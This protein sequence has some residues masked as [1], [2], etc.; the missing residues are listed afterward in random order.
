MDAFYISRFS[1]VHIWILETKG[2]KYKQ[3]PERVLPGDTGSRFYLHSDEVQQVGA[4]DSADMRQEVSS[5][6]QVLQRKRAAQKS[7]IL[8]DF[9]PGST[10]C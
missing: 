2:V 7:F 1:H 5:S 9:A 6:L 10:S 4:D 3:R 8:L